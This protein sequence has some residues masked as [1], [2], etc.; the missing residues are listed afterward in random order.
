MRLASLRSPSLG[1]SFENNEGPV[2]NMEAS[3]PASY[4]PVFNL[5]RGAPELALT[6]CLGHNGD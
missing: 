3:R 1:H 2:L 6:S 5:I 4:Q